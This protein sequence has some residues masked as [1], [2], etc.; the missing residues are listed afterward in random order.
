MVLVC[1]DWGGLTG[2]SVGEFFRDIAREQSLYKSN[3]MYVCFFVAKNLTSGTCSI[4][5]YRKAF[6]RTKTGV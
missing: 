4:I 1:Q 5:I 3:R 2:L 6:Y